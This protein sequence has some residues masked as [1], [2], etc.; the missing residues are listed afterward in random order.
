MFVVTCI[1]QVNVITIYRGIKL[2][3]RNEEVCVFYEKLNVQGEWSSIEVRTVIT[4]LL[5][6][7]IVPY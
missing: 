2:I 7:Y 6:I 5:Y 3:E 4:D 1:Y